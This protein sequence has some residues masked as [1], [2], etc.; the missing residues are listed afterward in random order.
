MRQILLAFLLVAGCG[1]DPGQATDAGAADA[2]ADAAIDAQADAG[3]AVDTATVDAVTDSGADVPDAAPA[4]DTANGDAA[5]ACAVAKCDDGNPCTDDSCSTTVGCV[6][7]ANTLP[8]DDGKACT[9]GDHCAANQCLGG[10]PQT[11]QLLAGGAKDDA[12]LAVLPASDGGLMAAGWTTSK[13]AGGRDAWLMRVGPGGKLAW[14]KTFGGDK[15]DEARTLQAVGSGFAIAGSTTSKGAGKR[16]AWLVRVDGQGAFL[17]ES[18]FGGDQDEE[19]YGMVA[20]ADGYLLA[21][22]SDSQEAGKTHMW[23]VRAD[24]IGKTMWSKAFGTTDLDAAYGAV[25]LADGGFAVVGET[26][27]DGAEHLWLL[28]IDAAGNLLWDKTFHGTGSD[29]GWAIADTGSGFALGGYAHPA[30]Q[31][32]QAWLVTT[33]ATGKLASEQTFGAGEVFGLALRPDGGILLAGTHLQG[34]TSKLWL[35]AVGAAGTPTWSK[36]LG[37]GAQDAAHAI[38]VLPDGGLVVAATVTT[39]SGKDTDAWLLRTDA[40]GNWCAK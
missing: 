25:A 27:P 31:P 36:D 24:P 21:G 40:T 4:G 10:E 33:D 39:A 6:H 15:N 32:K 38:A 13:G 9:V 1:D 12:A 28:R 14:D 8:C 5:P 18:T 37:G 30:D 3:G 17:G 29:T 11:W 34:S 35:Q 7:I 22:Y 19:I 23:L 16:D 20:S 2:A 26:S